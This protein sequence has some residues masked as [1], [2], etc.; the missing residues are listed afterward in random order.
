VRSLAERLADAFRSETPHLLADLAEA[1][2]RHDHP[3][4]AR[5]AHNIKGSAFYIG[6]EPMAD[7][8]GGLEDACDDADEA[9]IATHWA[10]LQRSIA[11]W[12]STH[13]DPA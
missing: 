5:I 1:I 4:A 10:A 2:E 11:D 9:G 13:R 7:D 3:R 6:C 12:M 8:A